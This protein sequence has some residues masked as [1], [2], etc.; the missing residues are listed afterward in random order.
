MAADSRALRSD[1]EKDGE[2]EGQDGGGPLLESH[3]GHSGVERGRQRLNI[4]ADSQRLQLP[5]SGLPINTSWSH[6]LQNTQCDS[7]H[8]T[9]Q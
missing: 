6:D 1:G 7:F 9:R 3:G 4:D 8:R 2:M 5:T